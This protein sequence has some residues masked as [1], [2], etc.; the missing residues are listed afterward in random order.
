LLENVG[1]ISFD[2]VIARTAV[3]INNLLKGKSKQ[4]DMADLFI[5]ATA[6]SNNFSF[7][8]LNRKHFYKIYFLDIV[9]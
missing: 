8:T 7:A 9:D 3:I 5:A 1:I 2:K 6:V 4:I